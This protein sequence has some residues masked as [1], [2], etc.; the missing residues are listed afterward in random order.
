M[1]NKLSRELKILEIDNILGNITEIFLTTFL[2]AYFYKISA[3]NIKYLSI[4]N[5]IDYLVAT[6][7]AFLLGDYIKRKN[8]IRLYRL[9]TIIK[10]LYILLIIV[11]KERII[12][13]IYLIGFV[14]G[15]GTCTQGFSF[16]MIESEQISNKERTKYLSYK[17]AGAEIASIL[18]PVLLGAYITFSSYEIAAVLIFI[19]SIAKIILTFFIKNKNKETNSIDL[20]EFMKIVKSDKKINKLYFIEFLKGMTRYGVMSLVIS[21]L[22][23]YELKTE[24][25]LGA[26]TS[27]FS[28]LTIIAMALFAKYYNKNKENFILN[29]CAIAILISFV[30][31]LY[32]I[33]M[34][35]II[36]Y[37]TVYYIFI[38][39]LIN[40]TQKRLFDY[41]NKELLKDKYN[42]EFFILRELYLNIGR[43]IGYIILLFVGITHNM[44]ILKVLLLFIT[45]ALLTMIYSSKKLNTEEI[46][47]M[48]GEV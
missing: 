7:G 25:K 6:V 34:T 47:N 14:I 38:N 4:Y 16:N 40:I 1:K 21:L 41:S 37:N 27:V 30:L 44:N 23:I 35:T 31:M 43:E 24:L 17:T 9:G 32:S 42:T 33:N 12:D 10:A 8:K 5:I 19:F 48:E 2:A 20:K 29:I 11:L 3:D 26:L 46:E 15:L 22:V 18:V 28:I 13:Y 45:I 36:T 39:I